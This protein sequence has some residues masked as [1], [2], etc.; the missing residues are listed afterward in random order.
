VCAAA[1]DTAFPCIP[2]SVTSGSKPIA[3]TTAGTNTGSSTAPASKP[4]PRK[5]NRVT[6]TASPS[7]P[8]S[9]PSTDSAATSAEVVIARVHFAVR[10]N[11]RYHRSDHS[12]VGGSS[13]S[14]GANDI[15]T[16]HRNGASSASSV[17]TPRA[18][19]R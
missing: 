12:S 10:K 18:R 9:D 14:P 8:A 13:T 17:N 11:S 5:W 15:H 16:A 7:P 6:A 1:S 2:V 19:P 4:L 3:S